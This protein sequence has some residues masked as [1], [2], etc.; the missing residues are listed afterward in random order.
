MMMSLFLLDSEFHPYFFGVFSFLIYL[1]KHS[2]LILAKNQCSAELDIFIFPEV[3]D[4][5]RYSN[6]I[7]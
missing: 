4:E 7:S 1:S 2:M 5:F 6:V 3:P